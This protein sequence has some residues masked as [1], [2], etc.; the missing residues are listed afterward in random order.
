MEKF[1]RLLKNLKKYIC[2]LKEDIKNLS[3]NNIKEFLIKRKLLLS[4]ILV[5]FILIGFWVGSYKASKDI[6]LKNLEISLKENKPGRIFKKIRVDDKKISKKDL[7]P[8]SEYYSDNT[9]QVDDIIR[10]LKS[11]EKSRFFTLK[12]DKILFF[13]NYKIQIEPVSIKINT[14]F[15]DAKIYVD[16]GPID[17]TKIKRGELDTLYGEVVEE[18]EV[19]LMQ[20]EE[21]ILN[22]KAININLSSN[23]DDADVVINDKKVNKKVKD[24]KNYGPIPINKDITI[25]LEREFPWGVLK[26][27]KVNVGDLPN[28]NIDINMANDKLLT[29]IDSCTNTFYS[30]VFDALNLNN[31]SLIKNA[32][33]NAKNKIYDSVRRESLFLKNNYELTELNTEVKSSEFYYEDNTYKAN[34]VINLNYSVSKKLIPF[35]KDNVNEMFLTQM[36]Y[37]DGKWEITDVQK[38]NLE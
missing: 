36:E 17:A 27:E 8:L 38:F 18:Q 21:Y 31:Y 9:N 6:V 10:G 16:N 14:N 2:F 35:I 4:T 25:S 13:N 5:F 33:E 23:F 30:S 24:I 11:N 32:E 12:N 34:I 22:L 7:Q 3:F 19:F 1:D 28:I 15:D 29:E 20:N 37:V 26:S